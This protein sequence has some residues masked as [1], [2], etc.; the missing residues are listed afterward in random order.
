MTAIGHHVSESSSRLVFGLCGRGRLR[1]ISL[2]SLGCS[3]NLVGLW[4]LR[5]TSAWFGHSC[6]VFPVAPLDWRVQRSTL[7]MVS[8]RGCNQNVHLLVGVDVRPD[9]PRGLIRVSSGPAASVVVCIIASSC[10]R[11]KSMSSATCWSL[12]AIRWVCFRRRVRLPLERFHCGLGVA[13]RR[14]RWGLL[15]LGDHG[16]LPGGWLRT[17]PPSAALVVAPSPGSSFDHT[18]RP[19]QLGR[20]AL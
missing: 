18:Q 3:L 17:V 12:F 14:L 16:A 15:S 11:L 20:G 8:P 1:A 5:V 7:L 9:H 19:N 6:I 4:R 10:R 2:Q 13:P